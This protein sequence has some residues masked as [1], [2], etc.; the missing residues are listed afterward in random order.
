ML[1]PEKILERRMGKRG[2]Q[3]VARLLI[4][5]KNSSIA[6]ATLEFA[7][8]LSMRFPRFSLEDKGSWE[9]KSYYKEM[10]TVE[11]EAQANERMHVGN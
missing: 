9:G 1:E 5:W 11:A 10:R 3:A 8:E 7:S 6:E 4:Q 2:N